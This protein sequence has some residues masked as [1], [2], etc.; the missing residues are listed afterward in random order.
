MK[1]IEEINRLFDSFGDEPVQLRM[2]GY[3]SERLDS[4]LSSNNRK[5]IKYVIDI[6]PRC[7]MYKF[8]V[9]VISK[10]R[11]EGIVVLSSHD[12]LAKLIKESEGYV[13]VRVVDVY[14]HLEEKGFKCRMPVYELEPL[15]EEYDVGFPLEDFERYE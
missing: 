11:E 8:N 1:K 2:G 13:G 9:P 5:K 4:I 12:Y 15:P 10:P 14:R 6:N 3:H 7:M